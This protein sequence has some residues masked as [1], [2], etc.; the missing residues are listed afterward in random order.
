MRARLGRGELERPG[1]GDPIR[2]DDL[3]LR[4][5]S[6]A[7]PNAST[8]TAPVAAPVGHLCLDRARRTTA[9]GVNFEPAAALGGELNRLHVGEVAAVELDPRAAGRDP[10]VRRSVRCRARR[11]ASAARACRPRRRRRSRRLRRPGRQRCPRSPKSSRSRPRSRSVVAIRALW[12]SPARSPRP[13]FLEPA[14]LADGLAPKERRYGPG[15]RCPIRPWSG[16]RRRS[17]G[18]PAP[19]RAGA[20]LG[21]SSRRAVYARGRCH[22]SSA[23]RAR[24]D[25]PRGGFSRATP[26]SPDR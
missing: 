12:A 7:A 10:D 17:Y 20:G 14:G 19:T 23:G 26:A 1:V 2:R 11:R 9:L 21:R 16:F 6:A 5:V 18:S 24:S 22:L 15:M 8:R 13:L 3:Q 25:A 4:R